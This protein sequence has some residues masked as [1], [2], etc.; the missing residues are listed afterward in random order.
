M[1]EAPLCQSVN[2]NWVHPQIRRGL[3]A[4][5][6]LF[7]DNGL[8]FRAVHLAMTGC[9]RFGQLFVFFEHKS[10]GFSISID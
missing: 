5:E 7:L 10:S 8:R 4:F 1:E 3:G 6:S 2:R 9:L